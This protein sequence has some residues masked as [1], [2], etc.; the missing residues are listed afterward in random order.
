M[1]GSCEISTTT[2]LVYLAEPDV[3]LSQILH[4]VLQSAGFEVKVF[5]SESE[6]LAAFGQRDIRLP[7]A[8]V[9]ATADGIP[10]SSFIKALDEMRQHAVAVSPPELI[11]MSS[12][13]DLATRLAALRAGAHACLCKPFD[14]DDLLQFLNDLRRRSTVEPC[15]ALVVDDELIALEVHTAALRAAGI[16]ARGLSEPLRLLDVMAEFKPD[17]VVLDLYMPDACGTELAAILREDEIWGQMDLPILFLSSETDLERQLLALQCGGDDFLVKPVRARQLVTAVQVRADRARKHNALRRQ[18]KNALYERE[19]ERAVLDEHAIVSATDSRGDIRYVNDKFCEISGYTREELLGRNHRI[20]KSGEHQPEFYSRLWQTIAEGRI[21]QGEV[22]NRRKD[23]SLYWVLSTVVP[24][25]AEDGLPYQYVSIRTDITAVKSV[26]SSLRA[27][28][29]ATTDGILAID[30]NGRIVFANQQFLDMWRLPKELVAPGLQDDQLLASAHTQLRDPESFL[31]QVRV[32]YASDEASQGMLEFK[33]GRVFHRHSKPM[34]GITGGRVWSFHDI[35]AQTQAEEAARAHRERLRR[36]QIFANIGTWDWNIKTGDLYWTER[37]APLFGYPEGELDTSYEN[38]LKAVHPDDRPAVIEAVN[39]CVERDVPYEIEH[40]VVWP[41]GTVRWLLERGAIVRNAQGEA[42]QM[43]GVVQDID[44]RKRAE[45]ALAQ[46]ERELVEAQSIAHI[47][48]WTA[49]L[50]SGELHWSDEIYRI[51]GY[52]PGSFS[53]SVAAFRAA[54]YPDDRELVLASEKEAAATGRHDVVHRI[55]R[56]DGTVRHVHELARAENDAAGRLVRLT[57]TVQDVTAQVEAEATLRETEARFEFAVNGAGDGVW[58]WDIDTG[59][60]PLSGNYEGMLGYAPGEI[61]PTIDAWGQMC[62][63]D[64]LQRVQTLLQDYSEGRARAYAPEL[65]LRC[66]DGS[67]KWI[68]CRG[69]IVKRDARGRPLRM[70]GIHSDLSERKHA[71]ERLA[72]FRRI[73]DASEQAVGVTDRNGRLLYTNPAHERALG[74][75]ANDVL[76]KSVEIFLPAEELKR[77]EG[78]MMAALN[79]GQGWSGLMKLQRLD[80]SSFAAACNVGAVRDERGEIQYL[81]NLFTDF[82]KEMARRAELAE[83]KEAAERASQA[84]SEFLSSM[85]HELRTPLNAIIGFGQLMEYDKALPG[86]HKD[87]VHEILKAGRH[88][89]ELINEVL[90]LAKVESGRINLSLEPVELRPLIEE[91]MSLIRPLAENRGI[92]L[93][94]ECIAGL[95]IRADRSRTRQVLLNLL[96]NAVKYNRTGGSVA[97]EVVTNEDGCIRTRVRDTGE[98]IPTERLG[99]LFQPFNRL[100][101]EFKDIEGTGIGLTITRRLVEL[102][103]GEMGVESEVG[104]GSCFWFELPAQ[105]LLR[106]EPLMPKEAGIQKPAP[107]KHED[108]QPHDHTVLYIEDNPA[109]LKIVAQLLGRLPHIRLLTAHTAELGLELAQA[110]KPDLILLDINMPGMD[111]YAALRIIQADGRLRHIPVVALTANAMPRDIEQ[112]LAAG[113]ADY[114]TK[115][116]DFDRFFAALDRNLKPSDYP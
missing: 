109:N 33:D 87:N 36:G 107:F 59:E 35:T 78:E 23:G 106:H 34:G 62:H 108:F 48:N 96:S 8:M 90:D 86:D 83:A 61:E 95:G 56:P 101:A 7:L 67:Y 89:L 10:G 114:L 82:S 5:L 110:R 58:D 52:E 1:S 55:V 18:L 42:L 41:D 50:Q 9:L 31:A 47:G 28:L 44:E 29:D 11:V 72:L 85:S 46:R 91:S 15:R 115:P 111:G 54:V 75:R 100:D 104:V 38:F 102:M 20:I 65:R 14:A 3:A 22:C 12:R 73:F 49:D 76:G 39:A 24:F 26:E 70:I 63:P 17:V 97:V 37:I 99:E 13:S 116:L 43:L 64:D 113:F 68:L 79:K 84:K 69:T 53:P 4:D 98:G 92:T 27:T 74:H 77:F 25:V 32:L 71:E 2:S 103:G 60:M 93:S 81:F 45:M 57:G 21:W 112:G 105:A 66:K 94:L 19:R 30:G 80:G 6:L 88:L 40:R 16:N 51:F